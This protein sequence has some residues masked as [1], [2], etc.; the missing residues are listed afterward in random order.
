MCFLFFIFVFYSHHTTYDDFL[1]V[2][3]FFLDVYPASSS[4]FL[5]TIFFKK[6]I[7]NVTKFVGISLKLL[8]EYECFH[9]W[10]LETI[11]GLPIF[12][13]RFDN[14]CICFEFVSGNNNF[15]LTHI[16]CSSRRI[17]SDITGAQRMAIYSVTPV[18]STTL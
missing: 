12:M 8:A 9:V 4:F 14:K 6:C 1:Y 18:S 10:R 5:I 3:T 17:P 15:K 13:I 16:R 2:K 11:F 7:T